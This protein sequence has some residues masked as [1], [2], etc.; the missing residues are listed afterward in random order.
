MPAPLHKSNWTKHTQTL[1][2]RIATVLDDKLTNAAREAKTTEIKL[3]HP[4]LRDDMTQE[5]L[6]NTIIDVPVTI[7]GSWKSRRMDSKHG[8]VTAISVETG[9]VLDRVYRTS[10]CHGC[11]WWKGKE[12]TPEHA[13]WL[14]DH[15]DVCLLNH[16]S[17]AQSMEAEGVYSMYQA[18]V[19][20]RHT[21]YNP[22]IG[23]GDSKSFHR[24]QQEDVYDGVEL[25][26]EECVGHVQKRMGSR[27]C[28]LLDRNK[29]KFSYNFFI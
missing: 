1:G 22:Y 26:K 5:G 18:S 24:L 29:G 4:D 16:N 3:N 7:D 6:D 21:R 23:D 12:G 9:K 19:D 2:Q 8:F 20:N 14:E 17:S 27:L 28:S 11:A 25:T 13:E 15:L 10:R